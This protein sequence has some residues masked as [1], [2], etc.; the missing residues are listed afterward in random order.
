MI[1]YELGGSNY[2]TASVV[3]SNNPLAIIEARLQF[4]PKGCP[5]FGEERMQRSIQE[6]PEQTLVGY[7]QLI[8]ELGLPR[9]F[10]FENISSFPK[11]NIK[12]ENEI[13]WS[14]EEVLVWLDS[15]RSSLVLRFSKTKV[16]YSSSSDDAPEI[17]SHD[18]WTSWKPGW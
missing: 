14:L 18:D 7:E 15:R 3:G 17:S 10:E 6:L 9:H 5:W 1:W 4:H 2:R 11:P 13:Y 16:N 8:S 12:Y